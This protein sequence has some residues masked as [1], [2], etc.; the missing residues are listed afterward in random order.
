MVSC[1]HNTNMHPIVVN[2]PWWVGIIRELSGQD[3]LK[4]TA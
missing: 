4:V 3:V 2:N 1:I